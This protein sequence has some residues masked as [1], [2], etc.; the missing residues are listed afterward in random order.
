MAA[1]MSPPEHIEPRLRV[2]P[3]PSYFL[4]TARAYSFLANFLEV[5]I[6]KET[7]EK[8]HGLKQDGERRETLYAELHAMHDLYYGLYFISAEDIGLK[9]A[10]AK[11]E[12]VD[13]KHCTQRAVEWLPK[14]FQDP[15]LAVD[16]RVSVPIFVDL[17]QPV[18]RIWATLGV[19][20]ARLEANY[21]R[22]PSIKPAKG[23]SDWKVAEGHRLGGSSYLIPVDEFAEFELQGLKVLTRA[24]LRAICDREK[25]KEKIVEALRK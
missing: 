4:R 24:E 2:E 25:T 18:T 21:A 10:L 15:D 7:L 13:V 16:T 1:G 12:N 17:N 23:E 8:L 9:T 19:R 6:G 3:C 22:P 11:E 5:A 14:A 20:L